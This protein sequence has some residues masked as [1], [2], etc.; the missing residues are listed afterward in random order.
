MYVCGVSSGFSWLATNVAGSA[1]G[2]RMAVAAGTGVSVETGVAEGCSAAR[3][4]A[5]ACVYTE[6]TSG[7]GEDAAGA[8]A[9]NIVVSRL[10]ARM[11]LMDFCMGGKPSPQSLSHRSTLLR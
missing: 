10:R 2:V 7:V 11:D 8:H 6:F 5:K 4:V 1:G 9:V 3:A